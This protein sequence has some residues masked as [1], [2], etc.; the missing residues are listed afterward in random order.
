M[1]VA[2][3]IIVLLAFWLEPCLSRITGG[4]Q[5]ATSLC[6]HGAGSCWVSVSS[7]PFLLAAVLW[8]WCS[9]AAVPASMSR[10][11][12]CKKRSIEQPSGRR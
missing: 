10:L 11:R 1:R 4:Y 8:P 6:L 3:V 7:L 2:L 5:Q 12:L 9:T